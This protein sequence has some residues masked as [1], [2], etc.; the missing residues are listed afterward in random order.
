[1]MKKFIFTVFAFFNLA[2]AFAQ[3]HNMD[4][5]MGYHAIEIKVTN[6][7]FLHRYIQ[8]GKEP[9]CG[10]YS[11]FNN[12]M[13]L[14]DGQFIKDINEDYL[15]EP[16][17][18][19]AESFSFA[20]SPKPYAMMEFNVTI[21][22]VDYEK[23]LIYA[24]TDGAELIIETFNKDID[25]LYAK[26]YKKDRLGVVRMHLILRNWD[27]QAESENSWAENTKARRQKSHWRKKKAKNRNEELYH[28]VEYREY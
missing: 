10:F 27:Y 2:L 12:T 14:P 13:Y 4:H 6:Q 17:A 26:Y 25:K 24:T 21:N 16:I 19:C 1:M 8:P 28:G 11:K 22:K 23:N 7:H 18:Q 9:V 5:T 3:D 15:A 20:N